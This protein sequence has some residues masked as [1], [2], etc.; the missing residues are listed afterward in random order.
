MR[1]TGDRISQQTWTTLVTALSSGIR[2]YHP[3]SGRMCQKGA[4]AAL[5]PACLYLYFRLI[6]RI[7]RF[8]FI[9]QL[10]CRA[11]PSTPGKS[12]A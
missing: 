1:I 10:I 8:R 7:R 3:L 9:S 11:T 2:G 5:M 4:T 12:D 6:K